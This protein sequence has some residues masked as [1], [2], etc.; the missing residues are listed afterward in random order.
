VATAGVNRM[1]LWTDLEGRELAQRWRLGRLVRPEGRTAWFEATSMDGEPLMLCITETLNDD[2]ELM[3]RLHAAAEIRHPNV[4]EVREAVA[5]RLDDTPVVIAVTEPAEENLADVLRERVLSAG[6]GKVVLDALIQ[7]L[8]AIHSRGLV[9]GRMEPVSVLAMGEIIKLRSDCLLAGGAGF[10]AGATENVR[11]LGRIVTQAVTRRVPG[12]ENDPVLQLLPE[13]M[14]RAMR[15]A[16]SGNARVAEIAMLAG[17]RILPAATRGMAAADVAH[18]RPLAVVQRPSAFPVTAAAAESAP[19][20]EAKQTVSTGQAAKS[21]PG[22]EVPEKTVSKVVA[23]K[24][25]EAQRDMPPASEPV[26][27]PPWNVDR[28]SDLLKDRMTSWRR[29]GSAPW[30]IGAALLIV[31]ATVFALYGLLHRTGKPEAARQTASQP[32]PAKSVTQSRPV[33]T[34]PAVSTHGT[35]TVTVAT[36]GWRVVAYTYNRE[37]QAEQ[38][39]QTLRQQYPQLSPGVFAPH[40]R[41]PY[42]VTLGSV[43]SK[44]DAMAL[45][46]KAVRAGLPRDTYAQNYR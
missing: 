46:E 19:V 13:P 14:A 40:G 11:G 30:V 45:R 12:G 44:A 17:V 24:A 16:L 35:N 20:P 8:A 23:M 43:M 5:M 4:L 42:L 38:K 22:P 25:A 27:F 37:A 36:P 21:S 33:A 7:A 6:E 1:M 3:E 2:E 18:P 34:P 28:A 31:L 39:A 29:H 9:H 32:A 41:S 10:A 15:R 26:F